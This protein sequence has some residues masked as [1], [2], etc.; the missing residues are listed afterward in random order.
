[1][2]VDAPFPL[3]WFRLLEPLRAAKGTAS[4]DKPA[5]QHELE[6]IA[7]RYHVTGSWVA[8]LLNPLFAFNDVLVI[9]ER[10]AQFLAVRLA[11]SFAIIAVLVLRHRLRIGPASF[12]LVPYLLISMEN[13]Y[14]WSHMDP[15]LFRMHALAY[16]VLFVGAAMIALWPLRYSLLVV[17]V[18]TLANILFLHTNS[19]LS[20]QEVMAN[21]G[22][23]LT[24]VI[25]IA[26][27]LAHNR[28]RLAKREVVLRLQ[29]E[30]T[31]KETQAQKAV[32][33][34]AHRDLTDSIRY[35]QRIQQAVL[36][37]S[38]ALAPHLSAHFVLL[39][40]R[41]I[42]SGD[43]HWSAHVDGRTV[44]AA[45][46]CTG[47]GVP[48][49]LMSILGSTLLHTIVVEQRE[50]RPAVILD[51][52]RAAVL[53]ALGRDQ[54]NGPTD[55]MDIALCVVD[56]VTSV[57]RYAGAFNPL[58]H[59]RDG[60]LREMA[61]DRMPV[62]A[63][64]GA[65]APFTEHEV[66]VMQGDMF[67]L[68]SDGFQDQF[69]GPAGRKFGRSRLKGLLAEVAGLSPAVQHRRLLDALELWQQE[70]PSID[71]VLVVGFR[72]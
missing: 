13:A 30:A 70:H 61:A 22:T 2:P 29:L 18:T 42:V 39:R 49:A 34:A 56:H 50:L 46:D 64:L 41:D 37:D 53:Q 67:Y 72:V 57:V 58:Y 7:W 55:G 26:T 31:T 21:G 69:G 24:S 23:L 12:L 38:A 40:A 32:I 60:E 35:S 17:A 4:D 54:R 44:V 47:H 10:G 20:P 48:G 19:T 9:P 52:L 59:V 25:M 65:L 71:D 14:M 33:E 45:A 15:A 8:A 63:H 3:H 51:R 5:W 43:F 28:Y 27:L 68:C 11:V 66:P 16:A 6:R 36:P 62:G 1:M